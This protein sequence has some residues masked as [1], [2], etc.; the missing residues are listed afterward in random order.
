[1]TVQ[2][3]TWRETGGPAPPAAAPVQAEE[4]PPTQGFGSKLVRLSVCMQLEG[5]LD[6]AWEAHGLRLAMTIPLRRLER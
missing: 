5:T 2:R 1:M 4:R 3:C 6:T